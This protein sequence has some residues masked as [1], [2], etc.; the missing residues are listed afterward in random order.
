[1]GCETN[2]GQVRQQHVVND[3]GATG[4]DGSAVQ[5]GVADSVR[6]PVRRM[7]PMLGFRTWSSCGMTGSGTAVLA[8]PVIN[9]QLQ[10]WWHGP[11]RQD[12][13][14]DA[15]RNAVLAPDAVLGA[16]TASG[17]R[18][19]P[20]LGVRNWSAKYPLILVNIL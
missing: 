10:N 2:V 14:R 1:M 11:Q 5:D 8:H 6:N 13:V 7:T 12:A 16:M 17:P 15:V 3:D 20:V 9:V 19:G 18:P 4:Q